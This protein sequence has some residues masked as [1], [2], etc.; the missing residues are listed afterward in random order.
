[1][2]R[3]YKIKLAMKCFVQYNKHLATNKRGRSMNT[4]FDIKTPNMT[5]RDLRNALSARMKYDKEIAEFS[6]NFDD[7][8]IIQ[9]ND[10]VDWYIT[11]EAAE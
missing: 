2:Q 7:G 9:D 3:C 1:M 6:V 10:G 11:L 8:L 4:F 5:V